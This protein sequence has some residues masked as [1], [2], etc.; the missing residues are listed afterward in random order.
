MEILTL[1]EGRIN[2]LLQELDT[3]RTQNRALYDAAGNVDALQEENIRLRAT[4]DEERTLR[5]NIESRVSE[6]VARLGSHLE[7]SANE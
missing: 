1:L 5:A 2:D 6:M 3:L 4:L 7:T